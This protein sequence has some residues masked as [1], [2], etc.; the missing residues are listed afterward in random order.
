MKKLY[1]TAQDLHDQEIAPALGEDE[2]E[3]DADAIF[4]E[5]AEYDND[6][7]GFVIT[8]DTDEFWEIVK[9]HQL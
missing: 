7:Q 8:V 1:I 4:D 9:K 6:R 3:H 5:I 2:S